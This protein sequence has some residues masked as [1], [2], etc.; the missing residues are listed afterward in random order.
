M[1]TSTIEE[2]TSADLHETLAQVWLAY[3]DQEQPPYPADDIAPET[4]AAVWEQNE[5]AVQASASISGAWSGTATVTV[6]VVL[7]A[8]MTERLFETEPLDL[9]DG[10]DRHAM[11]L[12]EDALGEVVNIVAGNLKSLLPQPSVL[13]LPQVSFVATTATSMQPVPASEHGRRLSVTLVAADQPLQIDLIA[14]AGR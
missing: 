4:V 8:A 6:P 10:V 9:S 13:S 7:A 2:L 3:L 12:I 5:Q 1:S 11:G 14:D